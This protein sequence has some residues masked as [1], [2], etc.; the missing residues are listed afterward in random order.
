MRKKTRKKRSD[1][2]S[3]RAGYQS[4]IPTFQAN[5]IRLANSQGMRYE[6]SVEETKSVL[7]RPCIFCGGGRVELRR[8]DGDSYTIDTVAPE[9][10]KCKKMRGDME[11]HEFVST[12]SKIYKYQTI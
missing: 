8:V 9:C 11:V 2:G 12:I 6:L 4:K 7:A 3:K 5:L 10:N 1:R